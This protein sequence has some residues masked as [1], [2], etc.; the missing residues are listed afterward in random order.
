[1]DIPAMEVSDVLRERMQEPGG[2]TATALVSF[3]AHATVLGAL[4]VGPMRWMSHAIDENKPVMTITL[5]G[6]GAGPDA[7]GMTSIGARAVQTTEPAMKPEALRAPAMKTPEM[8]VP[9]DKAPVKATKAPSKA[10]ENIAKLPDARGKQLARGEEINNSPAVAVTGA[11]GQ[12]FGLSTGGGNGLT[13]TLDV[14]DFC[15]PDYIV[16]MNQKIQ[17]NWNRQQEV[18]GQVTVKFTIQRDGRLLEPFIERSSGVAALDNAARR[19]IEVTRQ[20]TPLPAA[21]TNPA[22][23]IHLTF[24]YP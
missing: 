6:S 8:T 15:C 21:Y 3:L 9:I 13:S 16:L 2:L 12:G 5:G 22:L 1:M 24:E 10:T 7:G 17:G 18:R 23:T 19:A 11:K 14:G 20:L 4:I